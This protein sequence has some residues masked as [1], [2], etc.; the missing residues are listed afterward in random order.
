MTQWIS[1]SPLGGGQ[2][3]SSC[4][5]PSIL[6]HRFLSRFKSKSGFRRRAGRVDEGKVVGKRTRK[7]L[8]GL[9]ESKE[10]F[11]EL[12]YLRAGMLYVSNA[13]SFH[14]RKLQLINRASLYNP[15]PRAK[16]THRY[17]GHGQQNDSHNEDTKDRSGGGRS[18]CNRELNRFLPCV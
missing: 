16:K 3:F 1:C 17:F 4:T 18:D 13:K 12:Q 15:A 8:A 10:R 5:T 11:A 14:Q 6:F 7:K 2:E 9:K